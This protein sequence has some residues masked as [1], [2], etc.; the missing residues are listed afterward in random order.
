MKFLA[1][2]GAAAAL[3]CD[4]TGDSIMT[5]GVLDCVNVDVADGADGCSDPTADAGCVEVAVE[6]ACAGTTGTA[7]DGAG[8]VEA[9]LSAEEACNAQE[10]ASAGCEAYLATL[11][12]EDDEEEVVE[13]DEEAPADDAE[14]GDDAE[15]EDEG[16]ADG[17]V[18]MTTDI[19]ETNADA[20]GYD[21]ANDALYPIEECMASADCDTAVTDNTDAAE[22]DLGYTYTITCGATRLVAAFA[23]LSLAAAM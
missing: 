23:S 19:A 14:E 5:E 15:G 12:E 9:L 4:Y 17:E 13:D 6:G 3:S 11:V 18:L 10:T 8:C 7:G 2:I 20:E 1:L 16:C 22:D 21:A